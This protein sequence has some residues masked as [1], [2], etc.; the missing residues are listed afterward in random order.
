MRRPV[1]A[2]RLLLVLNEAF[3][4]FSETFLLWSI[5]MGYSSTSIPSVLFDGRYFL[6][7]YTSCYAIGNTEYESG[8]SSKKYYCLFVDNTE[9][10]PDVPDK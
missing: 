8:V 9:I 5:A 3:D 1:P 2:L 6:L 7:C 10:E 4:R